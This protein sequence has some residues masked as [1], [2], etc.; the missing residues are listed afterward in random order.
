MKSTTKL[1]VHRK[2][3][4]SHLIF[5]L[6][7]VLDDSIGCAFWFAARGQGSLYRGTNGDHVS[8]PT[9]YKSQARVGYMNYMCVS[10]K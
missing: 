3:R 8:S 2:E 6:C 10:V 5:P 4:V 1:H 7:T 9:P